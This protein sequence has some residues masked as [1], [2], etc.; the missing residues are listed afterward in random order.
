MR[1]FL[2]LVLL[3]VLAVVAGCLMGDFGARGLQPSD[4]AK[5]SLYVLETT[6]YCECGECCSWHRNWL[7]IPVSDSGGYKKVGYTAN[8]SRARPGTIAADTSIFPFGTIMYVDGYGYG[9]VE[10]RGGD[11]K[12]YHID[13]YFEDHGTAK[14]WGR[15]KRYVKVW[16]PKDLRR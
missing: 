13:L 1:A 5:S 14:R 10:D 2:R 8:G 15:T 7:F 16:F 9:R 11:I 12:G 4:R 3:V 6:G